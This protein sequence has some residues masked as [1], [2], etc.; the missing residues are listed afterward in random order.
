MALPSSG[1]LSFNNIR[2]ELGKSTQA[3]FSITSA[4]TGVYVAINQSSPSKPNST[5]PHAV[6]EWYGYSHTYSAARTLSIN[7]SRGGNGTLSAFKN[8]VNVLTLTTSATISTSI[9]PGDSFFGRITVTSTYR[10]DL[11]VIS[12]TRGALYTIYDMTGTV[13]SPTYTLQTGEDITVYGYS[14]S[15]CLVPG[16]LITLPDGTQTPIENLKVGDNIKSTIISTLEDTNDSVELVKWE[17][18]NLE[19]TIT[20]SVVSELSKEEVPYSI[21]FNKGLLKGS[22][23]HIQLVKREGIWKFLRFAEIKEGDIFRNINKEEVVITS[24]E[25]TIEPTEV[26]RVVLE[27]PSHTFYANNILTHNIK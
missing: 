11:E 22:S 21:T 3:P 8:D 13:T 17:T 20:T 16:T 27:T 7:F 4:A 15:A 25:Y 26:Y 18:D 19:E 5:A 10:E 23:R 2:T 12:S 6:S 14:R 24:I 1:Q 9:S